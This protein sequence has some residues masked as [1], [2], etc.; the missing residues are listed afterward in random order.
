MSLV[1][2]GMELRAMTYPFNSAHFD[3]LRVYDRAGYTVGVDPGIT[4]LSGHQRDIAIDIVQSV[5]CKPRLLI[6]SFQ[7][8]LLSHLIRPVPE[9]GKV[10][11][12]GV[13]FKDLADVLNIPGAVTEELEEGQV[14]G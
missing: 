13:F 6:S 12:V 10:K 2:L 5:G 3:K 7:K 14:L 11:I 4:I 1:C 8:D 9:I